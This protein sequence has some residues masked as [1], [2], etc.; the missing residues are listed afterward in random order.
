M[1]ADLH[2][3]SCFSFDGADE[4]TLQNLCEAAIAKG[5]KVL[6]VTDHCDINGEIEGVFENNEFKIRMFTREGK[7]YGFDTEVVDTTVGSELG[8][9]GGGDNEIM[10]HLVDYLRTGVP[11]LSLTSIDDSVEGHLCVYAAEI[12]R[13]EGRTVDL[14]EIRAK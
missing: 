6:A 8:K 3:H 2:T 4:S 14:A 7:R 12:S 13:K 10:R 5:L 9:H 1:F 11:S